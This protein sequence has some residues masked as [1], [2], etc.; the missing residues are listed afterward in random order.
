MCTQL[1]G[2]TAGPFLCKHLSAVTTSTEPTWR[3]ATFLIPFSSVCCSVWTNLLTCLLTASSSVCS[4]ANIR[5]SRTDR[6]TDRLPF[7]APL[8]LSLSFIKMLSTVCL[9]ACFTDDIFSWSLPEDRVIIIYLPACV[10]V[11]LCVCPSVC[12][13]ICLS[14]ACRL[15]CCSPSP[16]HSPRTKSLLLATSLATPIQNSSEKALPH[17]CD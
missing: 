10:S 2:A 4:Q 14:D 8:S 6:Q 15:C 7:P 3:A 16:T 11:C 9:L 5:V 1:T 17:S 12:L 13:F